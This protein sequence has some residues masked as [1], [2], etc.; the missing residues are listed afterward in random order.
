ML[1]ISET[2]RELPLYGPTNQ[3]T[4]PLVAPDHHLARRGQPAGGVD[5]SAAPPP[6]DEGV[7]G[8]RTAAGR[9]GQSG[10]G[11]SADQR[12]NTATTASEEGTAGGREDPAEGAGGGLAI[13]MSLQ[14][15][16]FVCLF[17]G[18]VLT[19]AGEGRAE[20]LL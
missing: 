18:V 17:V 11:R 12:Q 13:L 5:V 6:T 15:A 1:P 10:R 3:P 14:L 4:K 7:R 8:P 9:A 20:W 2:A 19:R 16:V